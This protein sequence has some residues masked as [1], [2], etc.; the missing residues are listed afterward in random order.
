MT[1]PRAWGRPTTYVR[2]VGWSRRESWP[3][4]LARRERVRPKEDTATRGQPPPDFEF[5]EA[6]GCTL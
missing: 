5:Q 6:T 1:T 4:R 2:V 3:P